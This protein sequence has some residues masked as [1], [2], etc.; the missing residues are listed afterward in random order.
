MPSR[1]TICNFFKI[2]EGIERMFEM[3]Q[4]IFNK[5]RLLVSSG[6]LVFIV[7][8]ALLIIIAKPGR[9]INGLNGAVSCG[10]F[11]YA[12]MLKINLPSSA[13]ILKEQCS[14]S[15]NPAYDVMFTMRA[16]DLETF[17]QLIPE[18]KTWQPNSSKSWYD[19]SIW[20]AN[21]KDLRTQGALL[22]TALYGWYG[23]GIVD[24]HVIIDTSDA[25]YF[26]Y[27]SATYVD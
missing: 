19:N 2:G 11:K 5:K 13:V 9:L 24:V 20:Q 27:Y 10:D 26:V 14:E 18:I 7:L 17:Q 12:D 16:N 4:H 1:T 21:E 3:G 25:M 23:N 8:C 6:L 15:F 22:K